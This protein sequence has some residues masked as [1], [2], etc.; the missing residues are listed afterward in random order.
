VAAVAV[1]WGV[2]PADKLEAEKPD[3]LVHT[4]SEL[5]EMLGI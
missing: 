5:A 4:I 1:T 2:F 3:A